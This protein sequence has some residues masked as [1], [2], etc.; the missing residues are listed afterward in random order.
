VFIVPKN[1]SQQLTASQLQA[2][3]ISI[4]EARKLLGD[5]VQNMSD[6]EVAQLVLS[7]NELAI[8]LCNNI[9]LHKMHL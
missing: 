2:L 8:L 7:V 6:E 5:D 4:G 1:K 3:P 9:D